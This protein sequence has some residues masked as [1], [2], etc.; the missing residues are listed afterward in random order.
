MEVSEEL[1]QLYKLLKEIKEGNASDYCYLRYIVQNTERDAMYLLL[2]Q[3][4]QMKT[5]GYSFDD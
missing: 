1:K 4:E 2:K 5:K 3:L